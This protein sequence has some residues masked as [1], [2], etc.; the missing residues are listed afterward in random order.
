MTKKKRQQLNTKRREGKGRGGG[1][2]ASPPSQTNKKGV[3]RHVSLSRIHI[4]SLYV[5]CYPAICGEGGSGE[6]WRGN[7]NKK[8]EYNPQENKG[9]P[10]RARCLVVCE[11]VPSATAYVSHR[12]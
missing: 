4:R 9:M 10:P 12:S 6:S 8:E 11:G 3:R 7:N 2:V 5:L 1:A